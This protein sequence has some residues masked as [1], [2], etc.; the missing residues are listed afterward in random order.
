M[1]DDDIQAIKKGQINNKKDLIP[2][3]RTNKDLANM[4]INILNKYENKYDNNYEIKEI[5]DEVD[6]EKD[7]DKVITL[8][9]YKNDKDLI[10]L[11]H[12]DLQ[13]LCKLNN[14]ATSGKF[15]LIIK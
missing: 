8:I 7:N 15:I 5:N 13:Y 6:I 2:K 10:G 4:E 3:E 9:E 11:K 1:Y 12:H 14:I